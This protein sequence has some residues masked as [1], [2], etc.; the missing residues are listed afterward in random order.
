MT[1][2]G[3]EG[4]A[5]E[6][7][8][9]STA[10]RQPLGEGRD[11]IDASG[12]FRCAYWLLEPRQMRCPVHDYLDL[13]ATLAGGRDLTLVRTI[14]SRSVLSDVANVELIVYEYACVATSG[15]ARD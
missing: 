5:R 9:Y 1:E 10:L 15:P 13:L 8:D 7:E 2:H 12:H 6:P 3:F 11:E 4:L 14:L